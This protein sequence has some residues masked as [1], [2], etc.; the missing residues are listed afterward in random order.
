MGRGW[1]RAGNLFSKT[2]VLDKKVHG[3]VEG[4]AS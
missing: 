4:S 3:N 1:E 2:F